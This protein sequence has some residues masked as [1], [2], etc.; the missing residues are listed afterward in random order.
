MR[1]GRKGEGTFFLSLAKLKKFKPNLSNFFT[2]QR[3]YVFMV[4]TATNI[5]GLEA[6]L[7]FEV[8]S[9]KN[10]SFYPTFF[11]TFGRLKQNTPTH[12][13][14]PPLDL[15]PLHATVNDGQGTNDCDGRPGRRRA[16]PSGAAAPSPSP[17]T[18]GS[19]C[20]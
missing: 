20:G 16:G 8:L 4:C 19:D 7:R 14:I 10:R 2:L 3:F 5:C 15:A 12:Q 17:G 18:T 1:L 13:P 6:P 9:A 11:Y